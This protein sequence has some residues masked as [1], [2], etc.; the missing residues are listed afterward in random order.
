[1]NK[2]NR[3]PYSLRYWFGKPFASST[4]RKFLFCHILYHCFYSNEQMNLTCRNVYFSKA[5]SNNI[6]AIIIR[7]ILSLLCATEAAEITEPCANKSLSKRNG[8]ESSCTA[9][10][11]LLALLLNGKQ[12]REAYAAYSLSMAWAGSTC[13]VSLNPTHIPIL[14]TTYCF[15]FL[16]RRFK[17]KAH[18]K[19]AS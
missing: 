4:L 14:M 6:T 3:R 5:R 17:S 15:T 12:T 16:S 18:S 13:S 8:E 19:S 9:V 2:F 10:H 7:I 1:M 11:V